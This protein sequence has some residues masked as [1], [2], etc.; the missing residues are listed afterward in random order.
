MEDFQELLEILTS[1][2]FPID[3]ALTKNPQD[4]IN[5]YYHPEIH[6]QEIVPL[7]YSNAHEFFLELSNEINR[8]ENY[9][10]ANYFLGRIEDTLEFLA[11]LFKNTCESQLIKNTLRPH[12]SY[13]EAYYI[14]VA[15]CITFEEGELPEIF[16]LGVAW[17]IVGA[18]KSDYYLVIIRGMEGR[19]SDPEG[20]TYIT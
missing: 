13:G 3:I 20:L 6:M 7:T 12:I 8:V 9:T 4:I 14:I 1:V 2:D 19:N 18:A 11:A 17:G 16:D 5:P 15:N 10:V